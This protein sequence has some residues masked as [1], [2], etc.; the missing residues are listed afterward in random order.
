MVDHPGVTR[1]S[2]FCAA[3]LLTGLCALGAAPAAPGQIQWRTDFDAARHEASKSGKLLFVL[4][5]QKG[6][7]GN[8]GMLESVYRHKRFE[9]AMRGVIPVIACYSSDDDAAAAAADFGVGVEEMRVGEKA[10]RVFLFGDETVITPQH[11]ILHPKGGVAWHNVRVCALQHLVKGIEA[12]KRQ[13]TMPRSVRDK[14]VLKEASALARRATNDGDTYARLSTL[15]RNS[16]E[17]QLWPIMGALEQESNLCQRLLRDATHGVDPKASRQRLTPGLD[18]SMRPFV[19]RLI[20]EIDQADSSDA[21][22]Y[23]GDLAGMGRAMELDGVTFL[24]GVERT[25]HDGQGKLTVVWV[26][27]PGDAELKQQLDAVLPVVEEF[28]ARGV[29]FIGLANTLDPERDGPGIIE[30]KLPFPVGTYRYSQYK[31]LFDVS[32][33]PAA[34]VIDGSGKVV[35]KTNEDLNAMVHS[36]IDFAAIVRRLLAD[37]TSR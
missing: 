36:Y 13:L 1:R 20:H 5:H 35:Y 32:M 8:D 6:E 10:A 3:I 2:G 22:V 11:V 30:R 7:V 28:Q 29:R 23:V 27:I 15:V 19:E 16:S 31:P 33:F 25:I 9:A 12:A 4:V 14:K 37:G 24:D 17:E 26:F 34:V 21:P 18:G